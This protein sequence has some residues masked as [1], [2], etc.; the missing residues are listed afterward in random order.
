MQGIFQFPRS[1]QIW[2]PSTANHIK[3]QFRQQTWL[4]DDRW[5]S[6]NGVRWIVIY[7]ICHPFYVVE[8]W[9]GYKNVFLDHPFTPL[10][11]LKEIEN[12]WGKKT[13]F[14]PLKLQQGQN[15]TTSKSTIPL[16]LIAYPFPDNVKQ[17]VWLNR[18]WWA[19]KIQPHQSR[20]QTATEEGLYD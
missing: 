2:L 14:P 12:H 7:S 11:S 18:W 19:S 4:T 1:W 8:K 10:T 17:T 13:I 3:K 16:L 6:I 20:K 15:S 9:V 5:A